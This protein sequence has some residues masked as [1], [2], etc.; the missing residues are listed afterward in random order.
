MLEEAIKN[1]IY[2]MEKDDVP[3][4]AGEAVV[5][6]EARIA[7]G[8]KK[9][10]AAS[11]GLLNFNDEPDD[12]VLLHRRNPPRGEPWYVILEQV[13]AAS[14]RARSGLPTFAPGAARGMCGE[15]WPSVLPNTAMAFPFPQARCLAR[16]KR[17]PD[18][19]A[20]LAPDCLAPRPRPIP[21][22]TLENEKQQDRI[23]RFIR[24]FAEHKDSVSSSI[25]RSISS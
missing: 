1:F 22:V 4:H 21:G 11:A 2:Q 15:T 14:C 3:A 7:A 16:G 17:A 25:S 19:G 23:D 24:L 12:R 13:G 8:T 6:E 5:A 20:T 10:E 9:Q 18:C